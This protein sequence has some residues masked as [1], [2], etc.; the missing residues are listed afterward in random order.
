LAKL[1]QVIES[2]QR[3]RG[4][5]QINR[6]KEDKFERSKKIIVRGLK[7]FLK[8]RFYKKATKQYH[9][10]KIF[11][12]FLSQRVRKQLLMKTTNMMMRI[13]VI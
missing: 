11:T 9:S 6:I 1:A 12:H 2:F 7:E 3:I 5:L 8:R 13:L 4:A 10:K